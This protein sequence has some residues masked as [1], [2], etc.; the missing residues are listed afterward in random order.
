MSLVHSCNTRQFRSDCDHQCA[1]KQ[2]DGTGFWTQLLSSTWRLLFYSYFFRQMQRS[3]RCT[4]QTV[5]SLSHEADENNAKDQKYIVPMRPECSRGVC[6]SRQWG[7][8][9]W[10]SATRRDCTQVNPYPLPT[11]V[12][13][14]ISYHSCTWRSSNKPKQGVCLHA[15]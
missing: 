5:Y 14:N 2:C 6:G 8:G 3:V 10:A 11:G 13:R 1:V 12:A 15:F 7:V 4:G 9:G